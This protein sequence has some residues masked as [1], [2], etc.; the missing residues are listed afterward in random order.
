[1]DKAEL[2]VSWAKVTVLH[3]VEAAI[4][5]AM[6]VAILA[7]KRRYAVWPV[8]VVACFVVPSQRIVVGN[9]VFTLMRIIILTGMFR[10]MIRNEFKGV[11]W[12]RLDLAFLAF[13]FLRTFIALIGDFPDGE[14]TQRLGAAMESLAMYFTCRCIIRNWTDLFTTIRGFV[15]I[16]VPVAICFLYEAATHRNIFGAFGYVPDVGQIR[17]GR[18]RAQAAFA[19]PILA[20]VYWAVLMPLMIALYFEGSR[21]AKYEAVL[22]L[23]VI[24]IIVVASA[25]STP[26]MTIAFGFIGFAFFPFRGSMRLIRWGLLAGFILF[27]CLSDKPAWRLLVDIDIAGGSTGYYRYKLIDEGVKHIGEWWELGGAIEPTTWSSELNDDTNNFLM[28]A[29]AGGIPLLTAFL[30]VISLA[31]GSVGR[32]WRYAGKDRHLVIASWAFGVTLFAHIM[33]FFGVFYFGQMV[34]L[35]D[36]TLAM[37]GSMRPP[38]G[39]AKALPRLSAG[40]R[41]QVAAYPPRAPVAVP[42]GFSR[43]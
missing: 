9:F 11:N 22:G 38:G 15:W 10:V 42:A 30:I 14:F 18:Y 27:Q 40:R 28:I 19:H 1:V 7:C 5:I 31:F 41:R 6:M 24:S 37:I 35:W 17:D 20:G 16:G 13:I 43:K 32:A 23:V 2:N 34:M 39:A 29:L 12:N 25:S 3:P 36:L 26:V 8:I 33:S 4:L 21:R